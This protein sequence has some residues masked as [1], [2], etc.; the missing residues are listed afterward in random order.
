MLRVIQGLGKNSPRKNPPGELNLLRIKFPAKN[1]LFVG[2]NPP[3][4]KF[5]Q[6]IP[7]G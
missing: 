2:Y 3:E 7:R 4:I 6:K 1:M 5:S